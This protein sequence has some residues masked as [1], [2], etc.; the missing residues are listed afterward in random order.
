MGFLADRRKRKEAEA[1]AKAAALRLTEA[2]EA[3][4]A[5]VERVAELEQ[6]IEMLD[7][8][9]GS[10]IEGWH[11]FIEK[12]G[13]SAFLMIEGVALIEP[14]RTPGHWQGSCSGASFRVA[15]GVSYRVGGTR[16][17]YVPGPDVPTPIDGGDALISNQ[18]VVF[19]G[20]KATREWAYSKLVGVIHDDEDPWTALQVT[21]RQKVS[22]ILYGWEIADEV[23]WRL[24]L[25]LA[26]YLD[27]RG[28]LREQVS[29]EL[30]QL[31]AAER[32]DPDRTATTG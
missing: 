12:K 10:D 5:W 13:E 30:E 16:G 7:T 24:T 27:E 26:S 14:R 4:A 25:A 18:R 1:A 9:W 23:R 11:G 19:I 8:W 6:R 22:G 29:G 21:N 3:R 17:T 28:Q 31:R 20:Q 2:R 32:P 15:K